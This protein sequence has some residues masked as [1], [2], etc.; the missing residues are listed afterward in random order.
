MH[1]H[2]RDGEKSLGQVPQLNN[3]SHEQNITSA[4]EPEFVVGSGIEIDYVS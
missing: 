4:D 3:M 1:A 2:K